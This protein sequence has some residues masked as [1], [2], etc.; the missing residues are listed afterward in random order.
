MVEIVRNRGGEALF[1][2]IKSVSIPAFVE[3]RRV[4]SGSICFEKMATV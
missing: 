2:N 4:G 1:G 3:L